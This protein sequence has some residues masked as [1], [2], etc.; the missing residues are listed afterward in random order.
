MS[1]RVEAQR[2]GGFFRI[3]IQTG[4]TTTIANGR[5]KGEEL[6]FMAGTSTFT[7]TVKG[8]R[9]EGKL[10]ATAISGTK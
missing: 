8:N 3:D 1:Q 10:G 7:G 6:T 2:P 4:E 9:L 5:L